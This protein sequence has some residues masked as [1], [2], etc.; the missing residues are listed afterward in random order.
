LGEAPDAAEP[1]K[2]QIEG[3]RKS[4]GVVWREGDQPVVSGKLELLPRGLHFEGRDRQSDI[5]Y[6]R[7]SGVHVGRTAAE[8]LDGRPSV[9]LERQGGDVV[10]I[11]AV[12]QSNLVGEIAERLAALRLGA[13]DAR[14]LFIV[15]PIKP[16]SY[17][18]VRVLLE[19]GPPFDPEAME[20]LERHEVF[21]T[22]GEVVFS[23]ESSLGREALSRLLS[24]PEIWQ[25]AA[26]WHEHVDGPPRIA[27]HVFSWSRPDDSPD[28]S[29]LPTPGP[30]DS[31]GGDIF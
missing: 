18:D 29:Y 15:L 21:L 30:G 25:A 5:P 10:T 23:F 6:E 1:G 13:R 20:G 9:V 17:D 3:M 7:L 24:S 4:Y 14:P 11:S 8:R 19:A 22:P 27:D 31:D 16:G 2:R 28:V 12:A 26:A